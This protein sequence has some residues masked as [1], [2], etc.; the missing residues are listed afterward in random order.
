[1]QCFDEAAEDFCSILEL[2]PD[3]RIANHQLNVTMTKRADGAA[4]ERTMFAGMFHKFAQQD[5]TV[6]NIGCFMLLLF[7]SVCCGFFSVAQA[8]FE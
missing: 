3:N 8:T 1:M 4:R 5:L 6:C 2:E 7:V